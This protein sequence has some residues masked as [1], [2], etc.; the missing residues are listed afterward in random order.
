MAETVYMLE[1]AHKIINGEI[2]ACTKLITE[3]RRLLYD[4]ERPGKYHY[5]PVRANRPIEFIE[6]FCRQS[7]GN[8]GAPIRLELYQKAALNALFGFVDD[9]GMR[10]FH[11]C[12]IIMARKNGKSTLVAAVALY[13][14]I[15]DREGAPEIYC[16]A[17]KREQAQHTYLE[18]AHMLQ[19]SGALKS[20]ARKRQNDIYCTANFGYI[21]A[22]ASNTN[23][24]DGL[25]AHCA[26]IDEL[27]AIR[28]RD[29]YDLMRQSMSAR[30]QPLL[31][32]ITT[33]GFIRNSVYDAQYEY[34]SKVLDGTVEDERFL[35]LIY[36]QDDRREIDDERLW[37]KSNPGL[38]AIKKIG[39]LRANV[40]KA[41]AS[42]PDMATV[43]VKDFNIIANASQ[44]WLPWD[45]L[46][47]EARITGPFPRYAIG[48]MD[49][50]DSV[51]MNAAV[52]IGRRADSNEILVRTHC[53]I[54]R[55]KLSATSDATRTNTDGA[56]YEL[57]AQRGMITIVDDVRVNKRV[58]L[59]WFRDQRDTQGIWP[60]WIGY[61]PWHIDDSL[62]AQFSAEFGEQTMVP[63]RQGV[64]TLSG[65]M[66]NLRADLEAHR[67]NYDNN[68]V[69]KWCLG[70]TYV[71]T[72]TNGNIQPVK[73]K[74]S[75]RIDAFAALL[76]AY[77]VYDQHADE[78]SSWAQY[79]SE[80]EAH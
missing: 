18:C 75:G 23:G 47:N 37:V 8:F 72:D 40:E 35:P 20:V 26:I 77:T 2:P 64:I 51:D 76:D 63:V 39:E 80:T 55:T 32:E 65:P 38:G 74:Q 24:M 49:A 56:P 19:H 45:V 6:R 16:L 66:K 70:N 71:R 61:D 3:Y 30:R 1:Y 67:I 41:K 73:G 54:P 21:R 42:P 13:M 62:L 28:D 7:Q 46:N 69:M 25:N 79:E 59:D 4:Y 9:N 14:L 78:Y 53:W 52:L 36:E 10:R 57:W 12:V 5:D 60:I 58:F 22:L 50:A 17:T 27:A 31:F 33:A 29:L 48:G 34:A 68:P 11:E 15:A 43:L 44:A